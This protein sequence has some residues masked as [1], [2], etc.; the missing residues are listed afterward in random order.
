M[1][2]DYQDLK[3]LIEGLGDGNSNLKIILAKTKKSA[4]L[5]IPRIQN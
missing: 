2:C 3:C 5:Q 1:I 4:A